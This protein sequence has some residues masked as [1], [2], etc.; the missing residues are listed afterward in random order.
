[1]TT[2][3]YSTTLPFLFLGNHF[4]VWLGQMNLTTTGKMW[5]ESALGRYQM[6]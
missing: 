5:C 6:K 4:Q 1:M 2:R 3:E